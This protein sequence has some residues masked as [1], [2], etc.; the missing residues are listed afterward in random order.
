M[1][2][3]TPFTVQA[4]HDGVGAEVYE[5]HQNNVV[6]ATK[7]VADLVGGVISFPFATGLPAGNYTFEICAKNSS[8][9]LKSA[10]I[11]QVV[12]VAITA[13]PSNIRISLL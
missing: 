9:E 4:D 6:V 5:L 11:V 13:A 2:A 1:L 7:P 12:I 8:Q 3:N 10:P